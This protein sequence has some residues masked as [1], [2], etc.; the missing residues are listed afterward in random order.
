MRKYGLSRWGFEEIIGSC[1]FRQDLR[2]AALVTFLVGLDLHPDVSIWRMS[3]G[4]LEPLFH[5]NPSGEG[6][7]LSVVFE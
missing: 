4:P 2:F 6:I 7:A 1:S 3:S 5:R